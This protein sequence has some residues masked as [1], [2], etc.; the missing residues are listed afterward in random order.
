M[1]IQFEISNEQLNSVIIQQIKQSS[2][3]F[4]EDHKD[5]FVKVQVERHVKNLKN[6]GFFARAISSSLTK[7]IYDKVNRE[8]DSYI[9][10]QLDIH[11]SKAI[12]NLKIDDQLSKMI[13]EKAKEKIQLLIKQTS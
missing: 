10:E 7:A 1:K 11:L 12:K 13:D 9:K 8:F 5:T 3:K 4:F 6:D 2:E